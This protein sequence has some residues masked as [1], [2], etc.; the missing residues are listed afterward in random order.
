M[1]IFFE[2]LSA[3]NN[4]DQQANI[5][6]LSAIARTIQQVAQTHHLQPDAMQNLVSALSRAIGPALQKQGDKLGPDQLTKLVSKL[7]GE[8]GAS[9]VQSI[10]SPQ[11]MQ[12]LSQIV[13]QKTGIDSA[14]ILNALPTLLPTLMQI[15]DLGRTT[16]GSSQNPLLAAFLAQGSHADLGEVVKFTDRLLG[17]VPPVGA[18]ASSGAY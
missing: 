12:Q 17:P 16:T 13:G 7:A 18:E 2:L 14:V 11:M 4:P 1:S 8:N 3:I 6:Q 9:L 10:I 15:L 5:T